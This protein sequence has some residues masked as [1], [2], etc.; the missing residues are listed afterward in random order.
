MKIQEF[1][2]DINV[3]VSLLWQYN[4]ADALQ[5]IVNGKQAWINTNQSQFWSDWY[6]DV[7]NLQTANDFGL[8]VWSIILNMPLFIELSPDLPSK[9]IWGFGPYRKNFNRGVFA[10]VQNSL[11]LTTEEKRIVLQLRYWS[12]VNRGDAFDTNFFLNFV[13]KDYGKVWMDDGL[14]M[15][16][17]YAFDFLPPKNL[18]TALKEYDLLP[19]PAAVGIR[20][21][22]TTRKTWGFG[23]NRKNFNNGTFISEV[24]ASV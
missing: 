18:F 12:F 11:V 17:T 13:F 4:E 5:E 22:N 24:Y 6:R 14:D 8:S 9:P 19:R 23:S 3:A 20:Y 1:F 7:F 21:I 10:T 15:T 2:Y 16:I